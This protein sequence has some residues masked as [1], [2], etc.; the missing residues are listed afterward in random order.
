MCIG[1][2]NRCH[3]VLDLGLVT[4][5]YL[6][7]LVSTPFLWYQNSVSSWKIILFGLD[8]DE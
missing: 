6:P 4:D 1:F 3:R 8:G 7:P 5:N 2:C